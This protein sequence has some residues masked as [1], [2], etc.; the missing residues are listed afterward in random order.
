MK[1]KDGKPYVWPSWLCGLLA[2]DD[3]CELKAWIKARFWYKKRKDDNENNLATWRSEHADM[4]RARADELRADG[5]DVSVEDQN[6]FTYEGNAATMGGCPDIVAV[7]ADEVLV[8]D[9]KTGKEWN[10]DFWQVC[11][12]ALLLP[13]VRP[14][15]KGKAIGGEVVY[16][17]R[18]RAVTPADVATAAVQVRSRMV[19]LGTAA[20]PGATPS[21][22][23]CR[24]C[25]IDE[26][27]DR[28]GADDPPAATAKGD[29]F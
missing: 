13:Q 19:W 29:L 4:V 27:D 14:E 25:D 2:G 12:Y 11:I 8:S 5:Y 16:R 18:T 9:C 6:K 3:H 10:K 21:K 15:L 1:P 26:C 24:F 28:Y 22:M 20:R 7:R 17:S 23:E